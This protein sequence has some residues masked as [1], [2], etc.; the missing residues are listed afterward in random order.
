MRGTELLEAAIE[1]NDASPDG[2][3]QLA[4]VKNR[5]HNL[6][7]VIARDKVRMF[8]ARKPTFT[9]PSAP[10]SQFY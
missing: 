2:Y 10:S 1:R 6:K 9:A 5:E 7:Q 3:A 4:F 8:K